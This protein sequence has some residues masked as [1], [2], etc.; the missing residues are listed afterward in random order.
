MVNELL[1]Y[2][3]K[4]ASKAFYQKRISLI[5]KYLNVISLQIKS[6]RLIYTA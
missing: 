5:C 1:D 4:E 3:P 2:T 6:I